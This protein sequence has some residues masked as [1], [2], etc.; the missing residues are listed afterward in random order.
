MRVSWS[1]PYGSARVYRSCVR[2]PTASSADGEH[3]RARRQHD[4]EMAERIAAHQV[5][6]GAETR[7]EVVLVE[8]DRVGAADQELRRRDDVL[9]VD[10]AQ[11]AHLG[12]SAQLIV[13]REHQ[14]R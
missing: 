8:R 7:H 13:H 4:A 5:L 14:E 3:P 1:G 10:Y 6:H 12:M 9:A 11:E 2:R